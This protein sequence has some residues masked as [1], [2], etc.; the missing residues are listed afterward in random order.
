MRKL[1]SWEPIGLASGDAEGTDA[2]FYGRY[3]VAEDELIALGNLV[4]VGV[5][6][7][8]LRPLLIQ[9]VRDELR[10]WSFQRQ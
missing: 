8:R 9:R 7:C 3:L 10:P 1:D 4:L 5:V 2:G 6:A